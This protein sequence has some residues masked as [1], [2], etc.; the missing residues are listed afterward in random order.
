MR[1]INIYLII[2]AGLGIQSCVNTNERA[3]AY[4]NFEAKE[5]IVSAEANGQVMQMNL[6][7]GQVVEEGEII[8][9]IDTTSLNLQKQMLYARKNAI[10]SKTKNII[11][12]I[13][14]LKEQKKSV[15]Q[16]K[17]RVDRLLIDG[18]ATEKQMDDLVNNLA[19]L[20]KRMEA[21][22]TQLH[23]VR[24]ELKVI[25]AQIAQVNESISSSILTNP[26]SGT[27]LVKYV[28]QSEMAVIGKPLYKLADL[29]TMILRVYISGSQLS[30]VD[31]G[32]KVFV[33]IDASENELKELEGVVSWISSEAEFTPKIIQTKE[34]RVNLVYAV[35]I[36]VENDGSLKI[37]MPGEIR[38]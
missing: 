19:V 17:A 14:V 28:E 23:N 21:I 25:D 3:D 13:E 29:S 32:Q 16:E 30:G 11:A 36:L 6:V 4:G 27:I 9:W 18:A 10:H 37:G 8:G 5:I 22:Q 31:I 38:F 7:E 24:A 20:D 33:N 2:I 12:E 1:L 34:E 35:K 15:L 26:L